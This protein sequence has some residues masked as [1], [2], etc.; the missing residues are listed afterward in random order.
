[1]TW[2]ISLLALVGW[3]GLPAQYPAG[4]FGSAQFVEPL[5]VPDPEAGKV[6]F[7]GHQFDG[8][9]DLLS[10]GN[11][12]DLNFGSAAPRSVTYW[13]KGTGDNNGFHFIK[14]PTG[15]WCPG[16]Y[17]GQYPGQWGGGDTGR[18]EFGV[19]GTHVDND[20]LRVR[21]STN[22]GSTAWRHIAVTYDG[23][24]APAGVAFY[25]NAV[26]QGTVTMNDNLTGAS[27]TTASATW[28]NESS[29]SSTNT[30]IAGSFAQIRVYTRALS[31]AEV[32]QDRLSLTPLVGCVLWYRMKP[33]SGQVVLDQSGRANHG[34]LGATTATSTDDPAWIGPYRTMTGTGPQ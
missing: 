5:A 17:I 34:T 24:M 19:H 1:M 6:K 22:I 13:L 20:A 7:S 4:T 9:D 29:N 12:S 18:L 30:R 33:G 14:A 26:A 23:T 16:W 10:I 8:V 27:V 2:L 3:S 11:V 31:A 15:T 32:H 25:V 28:G 21:T